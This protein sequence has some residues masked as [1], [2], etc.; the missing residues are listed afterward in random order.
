MHANMYH[1]YTKQVTAVEEANTAPIQ[2]YKV[3]DLTW[4]VETTPGGP[5]VQLTGTVQQVHEQLLQINPHYERDFNI[6]YETPSALVAASSNLASRSGHPHMNDALGKRGGHTEC[7]NYGDAD[8]LAILD[9]I[10]YLRHVPGTPANGPGPNN[11]GRVSC[12]FQSA[13]W[14]CNDVSIHCDHDLIVCFV[15]PTRRADMDLDGLLNFRT[16]LPRP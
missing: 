2:G 6:T 11:C 15:F 14:W 5:T 16:H 4:E 9:G 7:N 12:S 3:V 13:I 1:D 8:Y 10:Q